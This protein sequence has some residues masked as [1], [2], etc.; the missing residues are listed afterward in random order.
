MKKESLA[1]VLSGIAVL[2]SIA[3]TCFCICRCEP[4][5]VD[6]VNL[7]VGSASL[8]IT[9][10]VAIQLVYSFGVKKDIDKRLEEQEERL[11]VEIEKVT[12]GKIEDYGY[13]ANALF[14]QLHTINNHFNKGDYEKAL[15]GFMKSLDSAN[16]GSDKSIIDGIIS[17]IEAININMQGLKNN[18]HF[19]LTNKEMDEYC[20]ILAKT[21]TKESIKLIA[22][23]QLFPK[24]QDSHGNN[25]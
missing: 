11:K 22:F 1:L 2:I 4:F 24:I 21:G 10:Y 16:Q 17:Y 5:E 3:A 13:T 12:K 18:L 9:V 8:V 20:S 7:L 25:Q 6:A 23:I 15:D 14:I 19:K